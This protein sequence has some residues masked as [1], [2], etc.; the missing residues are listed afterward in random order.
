MAEIT[1]DSHNKVAI[2]LISLISLFLFFAM[3]AVILRIPA[4]RHTRQKFNLSD[5]AI[6]LALVRFSPQSVIIVV[7]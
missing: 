6:F 1:L 5:Y 2:K 4:R 3:I 7:T